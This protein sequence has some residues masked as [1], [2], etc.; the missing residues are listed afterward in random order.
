MDRE[1]MAFFCPLGHGRPLLRISWW[2]GRRA[3][4]DLKQKQEDDMSMRQLLLLLLL[5]CAGCSAVDSSTA[6]APVNSPAP[7]QAPLARS[8][9]AASL[10]VQIRNAIGPASCS[11]S[12]Q[13]KT[14]AV[15]A[16]ACGGPEGYLAY[17][18]NTRPSEPLETLASRHAESRRS[19]HA[20]SGLMS[21]C[22][23]L[24]DPGAVCVQGACRLRS[25][26]NDPA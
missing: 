6:A 8:E 13:C 9:D 1:A 2:E 26:V 23:M 22:V 10:L 18:T 17:S 16:R 15:G 21:T 4:L 5:G 12:T 25:G 19:A 11:D 3:S 20:A 14:L 7:V 24:P